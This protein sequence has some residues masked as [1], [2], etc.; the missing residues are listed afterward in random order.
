M[1]SYTNKVWTLPLCHN[2]E[3]GV[4]YLYRILKE[5][6]LIEALIQPMVY[7]VGC[8]SYDC[9]AQTALLHNGVLL[10]V[11]LATLYIK[12]IGAK[13]GAIQ[14]SCKPVK[15]AMA[16]LYVVVANNTKVVAHKLHNVCKIMLSVV[17]CICCARIMSKEGCARVALKHIAYIYKHNSAV[18]QLCPPRIYIARNVGEGVPPWL[19]VVIL[20][21]KL[22]VQIVGGIYLKS[23]CAILLSAAG[24]CHSGNQ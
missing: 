16:G 10:K 17:D 18:A 5:E 9:N 2:R 1:N 13:I 24:D 14:I 21:K 12:D 6:A 19:S 15:L 4:C 7:P 11:G 3:K 8:K 20:V 22:R 23:I